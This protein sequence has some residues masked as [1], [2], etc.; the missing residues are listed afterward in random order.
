M[1]RALHHK[2]FPL[3]NALSQRITKIGYK[4]NGLIK[5]LSFPIYSL[6]DVRIAPGTKINGRVSI[7]RGTR[8]NTPSLFTGDVEIGKYCAIAGALSVWESNHY[9]EQL[10]MQN[11]LAQM[12]NAPYPVVGQTRGPVR[13]AD[14]VWIGYDVSIL[15]GVEIGEGAVI[16]AGSVVTKSVPPYAIYAGNPARLIRYRIPRELVEFVCRL[17]LY[18][19]PLADLMRI[20]SLLTEKFD[21]KT[22]S[23]ICQVLGEPTR[24]AAL[25]AGYQA[26]SQSAN[27]GVR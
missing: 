7:G 23:E 2:Q 16:G 13:I 20:S 4:I 9:T 10:L 25:A 19:R 15:S 11:H 17:K 27:V 6:N 8:I 12:I 24:S 14:G 18:D 21:S 5:I 1:N 26:A 3:L 22:L